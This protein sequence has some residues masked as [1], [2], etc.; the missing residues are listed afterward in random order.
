M[1]SDNPMRVGDEDYQPFSRR[2]EKDDRYDDDGIL[3][4]GEDDPPIMEAIAEAIKE[5]GQ[6]GYS[7]RLQKA[8][9]NVYKMAACLPNPYKDLF[10]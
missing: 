1:I 5:S 9:D 2:E 3:M 6:N 8:L 7:P 4:P 10:K